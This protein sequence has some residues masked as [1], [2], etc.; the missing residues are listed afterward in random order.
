[1]AA[2]PRAGRQGAVRIGAVAALS[3]LLGA[4]TPTG[5]E[6]G[7]AGG[8]RKPGGA[9]A[10]VAIEGAPEAVQARLVGAMRGEAGTRGVALAASDAEARYR[11]KG[12]LSAYR[13]PEGA[14]A[15]AFVW[16]VFDAD[17]QRARRVSGQET[18]KQA[19]PT[20]PW[21]AADEETIRRIARESL[22]GIATAVSGS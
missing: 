14:T 3:A 1:M 16:D 19:N 20:D 8:A 17:L 5:L 4:C 12:Y 22:T 10:F 18:V 13:T 21:A 11:V 15:L 7:A 6:L 2:L 9:V